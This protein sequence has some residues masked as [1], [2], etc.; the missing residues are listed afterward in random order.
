MI[1]VIDYSVGNVESVCNAFRHIGCKTEL[2]RDPARIAKAN[3]L[4]LPGVAA[5]GYAMEALGDAAEPVK[6]AVAGGK[7]ILGICVGHQLLFDEST[8]Y[9]PHKGLG[10]IEGC[11][12]PVPPGQ[13]VPHMGWNRVEL[14]EDMDLFAGLGSAKHFYFAHSYH[15][16]VSDPQARIALVEYGSL[17]TASVQKGNI[18]GVQ[19]HP[20]KS[21]RQGLQVLKNFHEIC[22]R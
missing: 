17:L 11:V 12:V 16:K 20:E 7:P 15:A 21:S 3:G 5:F 6:E 2:S 22:R 10:L 13:T 1:V 8:E 14:P 4:V 9:G 19:F 18:Y